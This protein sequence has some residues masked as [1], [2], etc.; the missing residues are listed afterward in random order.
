MIKKLT[1]EEYSA[2]GV[3]RKVSQLNYSLGATYKDLKKY[4]LSRKLF[5]S[6]AKKGKIDLYELG[7][8]PKE[9]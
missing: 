8:M 6:L 4:K 3:I 9:N 5:N 2:L 7:V 1:D